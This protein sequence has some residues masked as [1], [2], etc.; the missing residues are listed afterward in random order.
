VIAGIIKLSSRR[1]SERRRDL[2]EIDHLDA[3][4]RFR[5]LQLAAVL[6]LAAA[7]LRSGLGRENYGR[8]ASRNPARLPRA[9]LTQQSKGPLRL[10]CF[11]SMK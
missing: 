9:H 2:I 10:R 6:E 7:R 1:S 11:G 4:F 5:E 3:I 8:R